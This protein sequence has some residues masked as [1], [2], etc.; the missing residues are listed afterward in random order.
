VSW[1]TR[2][3]ITLLLVVMFAPGIL[4]ARLAL[5]DYRTDPAGTAKV[6]EIPRGLGL[7]ETADLLAKAGV[8]DHP[9]LFLLASRLMEERLG[10]QAGEYEL[11]PA[12]SYQ[13]ILTDLSRGRV[14]LHS[15]V[16]PEGFTLEQIAL[17]LGEMRLAEPAEALALAHDRQF[18]GSLGLEGDSLEGYLFP[19]TYRIAR[20][21]G[22]RAALSAMAARFQ[23]EWSSLA[24]QAKARGLTR[25]QTVTLASI[26]EREA[27]LAQERALVSAV[28][29]NRL[30][31]GM[32]LQADPTVSYGLDGFDGRLTRED[33]NTDHPYNTYTREGLPPGP[34]CS[35]G[36]ASLEAALKPA[37]VDY[38][39]FV[40]RGDGSHA[41]SR[42]Y[43]DQINNVN[44]Y[45]KRR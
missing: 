28:Y 27:R 45:Q 41:F 1:R 10:V 5:L 2:L 39:Y 44:R 40:A 3:Y 33:L 8:I 9:W 32:R 26:I 18:I 20:G 12:M 36:R 19:D 15:L 21:R 42:D 29:H 35:P 22:A 25:R 38:L 17:R 34:I 43:Q 14:L 23:R 16:I 4:W 7:V 13:R 30:K 11:S 31:I 24:D 37:A 6:L